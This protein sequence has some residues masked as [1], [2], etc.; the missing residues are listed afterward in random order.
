MSKELVYSSRTAP[1]VSV[2]LVEI[3]WSNVSIESQF[4][5]LD[6]GG[7]KMDKAKIDDIDPN[8]S[9]SRIFCLLKV[10]NAKY[11]NK[12]LCREIGALNGNK[13]FKESIVVAGDSFRTK[14]GIQIRVVGNS[15]EFRVA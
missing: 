5:R 4:A 1:E 8:E 2:E 11:L 15:I 3:P 6:N 14:P 13:G 9:D 10:D 7:G 12:L